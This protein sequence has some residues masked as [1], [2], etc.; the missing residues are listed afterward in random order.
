[1]HC[2]HIYCGKFNHTLRISPSQLIIILILKGLFPEAKEVATSK[3]KPT[4][5]GFKIKARLYNVVELYV[6]GILT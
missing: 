6:E 3:K 4:T 1:M 5:A 2:I